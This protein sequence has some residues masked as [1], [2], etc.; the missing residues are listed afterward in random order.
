M[1]PKPKPNVL[2]CLSDKNNKQYFIYKF[3]ALNK[4]SA[5]NNSMYFKLKFLFI[6]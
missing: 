1:K 6:T 2:D 3:L 4:I 5:L